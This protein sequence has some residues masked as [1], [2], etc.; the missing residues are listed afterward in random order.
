M[1]RQKRQLTSEQLLE[2]L[3]QAQINLGNAERTNQT[4]ADQLTGAV[5]HNRALSAGLE[6][7]LRH[8]RLAP[9]AYES[10]DGWAAHERLVKEL[11]SLL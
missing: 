2:I 6:A 5:A 9:F 3:D 7:A 10:A 4:L 8:F 11:E 1:A